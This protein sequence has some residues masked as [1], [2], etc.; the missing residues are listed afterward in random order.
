MTPRVSPAIRPCRLAPTAKTEQGETHEVG[1]DPLAVAVPAPASSRL[2]VPEHHRIPGGPQP[3]PAGPAGRRRGGPAPQGQRPVGR[4]DVRRGHRAQ[5]V[6]AHPRLAQYPAA[7][8]RRVAPVGQRGPGRRAQLGAAGR[9][10]Q[11]DRAWRQ[12]LRR[13]RHR[14]AE[15]VQRL[16]GG[17]HRRPHLLSC[18]AAQAADLS[19]HPAPRGAIPCPNRM[20]LYT[21]PGACSTA[22]HIDLCWTGQPFE[23]QV[24]DADGMKSPG[25]RALNPTGAPRPAAA[26]PPP[27]PAPPPAPPDTPPRP[28]PPPPPAPP[29]PSAARTTPP[30]SSRGPP[31]SCSPPRAA[32]TPPP[33][34][35]RPAEEDLAYT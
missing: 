22:V 30:A 32:P 14:P 8:P 23:V 7:Q 1:L 31:P 26:T 11:G 16:P 35:I 15:L 10:A 17:D 25:F 5:A 29:P 13:P 34:P 21:K 9:P 12:P 6:R 20:K 4:F 28:P 24:M 3:E 2:A 18:P 33:L 19:P 27:A